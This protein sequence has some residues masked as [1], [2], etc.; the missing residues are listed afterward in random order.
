MSPTDMC[1]VLVLPLLGCRQPHDHC[2][3]PPAAQQASL[4]AE[5]EPTEA[6]APLGADVL[7]YEPA[8]ALWSDGTD[9]RRWMRLPAGAHIDTSDP[10]D[11]RFPRG[12]MFYKEFSRNGVR[13][14]TRVL[15]K[16]GDDDGAWAVMAYV[17]QADRAVAAPAGATVDTHVVPSAAQCAGCHAGRRDWVLGFSA[18]QLVGAQ[19]EA[20]GQRFTRA[21]PNAP[22]PGDDIERSALGY[23]HANCSHCHNAERPERPGARCFDPRNSLDFLVRVEDRTPGATGA[24]RTAVGSYVEPGDPDGSQL[25]RRFRREAEPAMP[26]LGVT[27]THP[28]GVRILTTWIGQLR[29]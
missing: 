28:E 16:V 10:N 27:K 5:L 20:L 29:D 18:V 3:A 26:P 4:D 15:R 23:L 24:Y 1:C 13:L 19:L 8:Y 9:K 6:G 21:V 14:E 2:D 22:I 25:M 7:A 11:W 12:T 17:W